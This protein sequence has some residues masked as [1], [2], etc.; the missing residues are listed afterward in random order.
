MFERLGGEPVLWAA[1]SD[2]VDSMYDD[3]MIGFLFRDVDRRRLKQL[4]YDYAAE[5]LG[6]P[7]RY[8]GKGLGKVHAKHRI[9]GGQ[10]ARRSAL[11]RKVLEQH[12]IPEDIRDAWL[13]H[14]ESLRSTIISD[15]GEF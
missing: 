8:R 4:E 9:S 10:F 2:F 12:C 1:I 5:Y 11:M 6:G 15:S 13:A 14:T 7:V 3:I